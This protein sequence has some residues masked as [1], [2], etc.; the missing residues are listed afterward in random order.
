M[1]FMNRF[2]PAQGDDSGFALMTV[3]MAGAVLTASALVAVNISLT[4]LRNAG[5]DRVAGGAMGAAEAGMAEAVNYLQTHLAASVSC[6]PTCAS[7]PWGNSASPT[8]LTYPD[9]GKAQVWIQVIQAFNPPSVKVATYKI[10]STGFTGNGPGQRVLKQTVTGQP[11]S[12]PIGVYATNI[13][14]NGT[15]QTFK[16][17]VFSKNCIGGRED[18]LRHRAGRL[19][20]NHAGRPLHSVDLHE[21]RF[22]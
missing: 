10:H 15:P 4:N 19:L 7:N 2:R 18:D 16:E 1:S 5:R 6:S 13:S 8:V 17:S 3:L 12:I 22:L 21:Q 9:G 14:M 20:R 11:L